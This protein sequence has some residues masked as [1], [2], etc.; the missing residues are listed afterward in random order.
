MLLLARFA[1]TNAAPGEPAISANFLSGC[2]CCHRRYAGRVSQLL[3]ARVT[4][5]GNSSSA[6]EHTS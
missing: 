5:Y 1:K 2:L 6:Y 4:Q 3:A